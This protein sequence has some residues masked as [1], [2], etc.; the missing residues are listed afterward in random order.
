MKLTNTLTKSK[1]DLQPLKPGHIKLYSCGPTVYHYYHIG[2]LRNA[3]FNDTLK[4]VL[5]ANGLKVDHIMNIT[6]VGHLSSDAD[7]GG[8]KLQSRADEEGKTVWEVAEFYTDA[9]MKDMQAL[10]VIPPAKYV[11][12]TSAIEQQIRM[13]QVLLDKGFA[14]QAEQ[15][16]YF[17]VSKLDDYGKLTDQKL[18]DKEIGA[19]SDVVT[20]PEK[21]NPQDFALWF[22]TVGHFKDHQMR[23]ETPW[24][25]GFP[26]W[27]LECSAIIAQELGETIDI[28][29]G[30]VDHIG[31]HHTNEIAQSEAAN[32]GAPLANVWLHNEFLLVDNT[33]MSKSLGN[34]YTLDDIV[35]HGYNPM[36]LRLLYLQSHYRSQQNFTF[37][38][39]EA[40]N[41]LLLRLQAWADAQFQ[42]GRK[43]LSDTTFKNYQGRILTALNDDL[44]TPQAM[45]AISQLLDEA[46]TGSFPTAEQVAWLE[47][48]L[49]L[50][51]DERQDITA[52]HKAVITEREAARKNKD[53]EVAD[54]AREQLEEE[55]ILLDD[56]DFGPRWY[57]C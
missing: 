22:F 57:R 14:Y 53:Y 31:T 46:D 29:T 39:L 34:T 40:A 37:E 50:R 51:L 44:N 45:V 36:A 48:L 21:R 28:H 13:V 30:G 24:G 11:K 42:P 3:I 49:G 16:I 2:N 20:D 9:F 38:T 1:D 10:N 32:D 25:E 18:T 55:S 27:H 56:T 7:E 17:D 35:R 6:D 4:R 8:D 54:L 52:E 41:N 15:A 26:G 47:S 33:K 5:I 12:A 43:T 23:W 19:R